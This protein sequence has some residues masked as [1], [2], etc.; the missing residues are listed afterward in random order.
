METFHACYWNA[1][2]LTNFSILSL[3]KAR[4]P[5]LV[6]VYLFLS[7]TAPKRHPTQTSA[8]SPVIFRFLTAAR[9]ARLYAQHI[10]KARPSQ[11][12]ML[13]SAIT[14]PINHTHYGQ[15]DLFQLAGILAER[16]ILNHA[17][18]D[19]NKRTALY[20]ADMFLKTN[21]YVL[22]KPAAMDDAD[23]DKEL[24]EAH[25]LVAAAQWTAEELG[26][27]YA[28]IAQPMLEPRRHES[29]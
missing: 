15:T 7:L 13:D 25:V 26:N 3:Y 21:G 28:S 17:Y 14:S 8:M 27:Y 9:A 11:P 22:R 23:F 12:T 4:S 18:Q 19:G 29:K 16:I 10:A 2:N 20:A 5:V 1:E 24:A 6:S